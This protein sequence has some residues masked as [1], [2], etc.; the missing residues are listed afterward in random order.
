[1]EFKEEILQ[2][3]N[4]CNL[5]CRDFVILKNLIVVERDASSV[6]TVWRLIYICSYHSE[7]ISVLLDVETLPA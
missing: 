1:M 2:I 4:P 7:G 5:I 3:T 6:T